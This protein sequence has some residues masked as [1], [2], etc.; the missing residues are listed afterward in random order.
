MFRRVAAG[1]SFTATPVEPPLEL[2]W[3]TD[4]SALVTLSSPITANGLVYFGARSDGDIGKAGVM[5]CD[6]IVHRLSAQ[7]RRVIAVAT[8]RLERLPDPQAP[9]E[10]LEQGLVLCGFLALDDPITGV[11]Y[12]LNLDYQGEM[13]DWTLN[14]GE[15]H[16][17]Q[18]GDPQH[19]VTT[20]RGIAR[21]VYHVSPHVDAFGVV[22]TEN[23]VPDAQAGRVR[24][25]LA[26]LAGCQWAY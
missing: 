10:S 3:N 19:D 26:V 17:R 23:D 5:A 8:R 22:L 12:Y 18:I 25:G 2:V 13:F 9:E 14:Y 24:K 6:A 11:G 1:S 4:T 15:F 21:L 16:P 7:G 20:R